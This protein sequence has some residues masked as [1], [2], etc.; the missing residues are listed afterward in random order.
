MTLWLQA[1]LEKLATEKPIV[2]GDKILH[3]MT[4]FSKYSNSNQKKKREG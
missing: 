4:E 1:A 2:S 3:F